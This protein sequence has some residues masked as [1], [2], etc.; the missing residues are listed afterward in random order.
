MIIVNTSGTRR[1]VAGSIFLPNVPTFATP[2]EY[3]E[4]TS[5]HKGF[6]TE[7]GDNNGEADYASAE[8]YIVA[9]KQLEYFLPFLQALDIIMRRYPTCNFL[10]N[11]DEEHKK[12]LPLPFSADPFPR[13]TPYRYFDFNVNQKSFVKLTTKY[14]QMNWVQILLV[15]AGAYT[16]IFDREIEP[17]P[18]LKSSYDPDKKRRTFIE[19]GGELTS[20]VSNH[21]PKAQVTQLDYKN[22]AG[23]D[24][25]VSTVINNEILHYAAHCGIKCF[26]VLDHERFDREGEYLASLGVKFGMLFD[27]E[28]DEEFALNMANAV[29]GGD[30]D[31]EAAREDT[32][33]D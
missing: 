2:H 22:S 9:P 15:K 20:L 12:F 26:A 30:D 18:M 23:C 33:N 13:T 4:V 32:P 28:Q 6:F 11:C 10:V 21:L 29:K 3:S 1:N 24:K 31:R 19:E 17:M 14:S 5:K 25:Y 8:I 16:T 27:R 7:Y